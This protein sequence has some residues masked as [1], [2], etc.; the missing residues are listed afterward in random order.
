MLTFFSKNWAIDL[1]HQWK[2]EMTVNKL[3][4]Y[5]SWL[6]LFSFVQIAVFHHF[7]EGALVSLW[8]LT[9]HFFNSSMKLCDFWW[10]SMKTVY[11]KNNHLWKVLL[12]H[13]C[14]CF[15][16][17]TNWLL[18]ILYKHSRKTNCCILMTNS[19]NGLFNLSA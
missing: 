1:K 14:S 11:S 8:T 16:H 4:R 10:D 15:P 2:F 12:C 18:K 17:K 9:N 3:T 6:S 13:F 19:I 7:Q 5:H